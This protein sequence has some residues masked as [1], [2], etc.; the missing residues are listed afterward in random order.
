MAF[1]IASSSGNIQFQNTG[2]TS[3]NGGTGAVTG[4]SQISSGTLYL[5]F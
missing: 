2:V 5:Y 4:V 3:F 1:G